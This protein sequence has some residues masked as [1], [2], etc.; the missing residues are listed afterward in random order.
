MKG[1]EEEQGEKET[2]RVGEVWAR[3]WEGSQK[4]DTLLCSAGRRQHWARTPTASLQGADQ[5]TGGQAHVAP[6]HSAWLL[7][8]SWS[9][10]PSLLTLTH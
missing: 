3:G 5:R 9:Y 2:S 6:A 7:A 1:P 10:P 4:P 8:R